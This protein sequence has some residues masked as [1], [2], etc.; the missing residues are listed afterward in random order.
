MT[1]ILWTPSSE[2]CRQ[3]EM[4]RF[5]RRARSLQ[6]IETYEDLYRWSIDE[7]EAFWQTIWDFC[8]I[9]ASS[10]GTQT[11][12]N[13]HTL[14]KALFFPEAKLNYAEN[15]LQRQDDTPAL[16]FWREDRTQKR[17]SWKELYD[18]VSRL[19]A[20][21][22]DNGVVQGDRV[23][24]FVP[25]IPETVAAMLATASLGA[26]WCS[27]SPDFGVAG[28]IER[29]GQITPKVFITADGY[30]YNGVYYEC[31]SRVKEVLPLLPTVRKTIVFSYL[32]DKCPTKIRLTDLPGA[33]SLEEAIQGYPATPDHLYPGPL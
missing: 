12:I 4:A 7:L 20:F 30:L 5:M 2:R 16:I 11:L 1:E 31:L 13:A 14:P 33:H 23:A 24:G 9:Q 3:S 21:L 19:K 8:E 25:N 22:E 29:F 27:C 32:Q 18:L 10:Q 6:P 28:V 26:I 15:L 17:M